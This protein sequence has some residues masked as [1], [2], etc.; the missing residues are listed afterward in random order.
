MEVDGQPEWDKPAVEGELRS[1]ST[2]EVRGVRQLKLH[3]QSSQNPTFVGFFFDSES[4]S[5]S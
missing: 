3:Q 5:G 4:K 2:Y 1:H